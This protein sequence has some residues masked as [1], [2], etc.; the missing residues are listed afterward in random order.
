MLDQIETAWLRVAA[1]AITRVVRANA[2]ET[3]YAAA[4]WLFYCDYTTM[5]APALA[6][7]AES[8]IA[9][10]QTNDDAWSTRWAPAEW[11]WPVLD[12]ACDAMQ[13]HYTRL[14]DAMAAAPHSA[15]DEL[16]TAHD[17]MIAR[18]AKALSGQLHSRTGEL[19]HS[20]LP[21]N[22]VV[23]VI[24]DQRESPDFEDLLRSSVEP[25]QL[26]LFRDLLAR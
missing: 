20:K 10:H 6:M 25:D 4:F 1:A 9:L 5:G 22:F 26:D 15:W 11:R 14:S 18:V 24:D 7:N 8:A 12:E 21:P 17:R 23:A 2:T 3:F 16:I 19:G 13:P